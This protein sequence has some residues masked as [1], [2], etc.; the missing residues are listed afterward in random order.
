MRLH[1]CSRNWIP[2]ATGRR[3]S[4]SGFELSSQ[5]F[6]NGAAVCN[7][8][9]TQTRR[10]TESPA[11][12]S[13]ARSCNQIIPQRCSTVLRLTCSGNTGVSQ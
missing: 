3:K 1:G 6:S 12:S 13:K 8:M 5:S 9:S 10:L 2:I 4:T 11:N 7:L